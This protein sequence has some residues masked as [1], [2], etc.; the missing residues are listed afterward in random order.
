MIVYVNILYK[1][2]IVGEQHLKAPDA[3]LVDVIAFQVNTEQNIGI[4]Q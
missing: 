1:S 4:Q 3:I 2:V